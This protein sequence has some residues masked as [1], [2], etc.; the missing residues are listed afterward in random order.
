MLT[1]ESEM[2]GDPNEA[3]SFQYRIAELYEKHLDDVVA[4][5]R[6]LSRDPAAAAR[7]R[8]DAARPSR[9]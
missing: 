3:I 7:S 6:A 5:G 9:A 1:R 4:R 8:A 2:T